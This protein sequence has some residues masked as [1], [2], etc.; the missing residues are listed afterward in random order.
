MDWE[1][2]AP[3]PPP[4]SYWIEQGYDYGDE[5]ITDEE[6]TC[7][8]NSDFFRRAKA[9]SKMFRGGTCG[10]QDYTQELYFGGIDEY[11]PLIRYDDALLPHWLE[12]SSAMDRWQYSLSRGSIERPQPFRIFISN[13]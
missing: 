5:E 9:Q 1:Y 7:C 2:A 4:D 3:D 11:S 6:Y 12:F 8:V 10:L 13:I